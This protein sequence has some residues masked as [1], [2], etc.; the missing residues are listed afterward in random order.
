MP[1]KHT[2]YTKG[3]FPR[4][5]PPQAVAA[6]AANAAAWKARFPA[7]SFGTAS[8]ST[9]CRAGGRRFRGLE[10][11]ERWQV[12]TAAAERTAMAWQTAQGERH[13]LSLRRRMS[14]HLQPMLERLHLPA[15]TVCF[16]R[17]SRASRETLTGQL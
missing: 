6:A 3:S 7:P 17:V 1:A 15:Q 4:L 10:T 11:R 13:L 5:P 14:R 2:K 12:K 8:R 16:L 9:S